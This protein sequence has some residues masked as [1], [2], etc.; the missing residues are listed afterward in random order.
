MYSATIAVLGARP[1]VRRGLEGLLRTVGSYEVVPGYGSVKELIVREEL[2]DALVVDL[3]GSLLDELLDTARAP[4]PVAHAVAVYE[5]ADEARAVRCGGLGIGAAVA[6][7][8]DPAA[9]LDTLAGEL[10]D[11]GPGLVCAPAPR[12]SP[13]SLLTERE[14]EVLQLI[15]EGLTTKDVS[16]QLGISPKTVENYK[17]HMFSKLGVQSRAH[18]VAVGS[19]L[20]L[21]AAAAVGCAASTGARWR[22]PVA[23]ALGAAR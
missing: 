17:Q 23:L 12:R 10:A 21:L 13:P 7:D 6:L 19:R 3:D 9:L 18:A 4:L 15:A 14:T 1:L 11:A 2:L 5:S 22:P 16:V 20:G 8:A